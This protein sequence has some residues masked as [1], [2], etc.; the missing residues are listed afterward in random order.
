VC[1]FLCDKFSCSIVV[2]LSVT[3]DAIDSTALSFCVCS[4]SSATAFRPS[5]TAFLMLSVHANCNM[6]KAKRETVTSSSSGI[7]IMS[8]NFLAHSTVL[9]EVDVSLTLS[10]SS[11]VFVVLILLGVHSR[12]VIAG[13]NEPLGPSLFTI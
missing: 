12:D 4:M 5:D 8:R 7:Y 13:C 9:L 10:I 2:N 6:M 3:V 1:L 11:L